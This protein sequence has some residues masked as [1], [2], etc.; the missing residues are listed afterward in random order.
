MNKRIILGS[1]SVLAVVA[2]LIFATAAKESTPSA[3][4]DE[5]QKAHL[6]HDLSEDLSEE[7][8]HESMPEPTAEQKQ[9]YLEAYGWMVGQQAGFEMNFTDEEVEAIMTGLRR[10]AAG[11]GAPEDMKE[12]FVGMQSYLAG[13]EDAY[14]A[15]LEAKMAEEA[16]ENIAAGETFFKELAQ[17]EN[18]KSTES[19]LYYTI[20]ESGND[21]KPSEDAMVLVHYT[22]KLIDGEVFDSSVERGQPVEFPIGGVIPGFSEGLQLL[23]EGG[24]ATLY[25]PYNLGYGEMAAGPI[26]AGS[27]LIFEVELIKVTSEDADEE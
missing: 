22:G 24:K 8:A 15:K 3:Q 1:L 11:E 2:L 10:S 21:T 26:P 4:V 9:A 23:G 17:K 5:L 19:G 12:I 27:T 6:P 14:R 7:N 18:V 16:K 20:E 13:K 25:I